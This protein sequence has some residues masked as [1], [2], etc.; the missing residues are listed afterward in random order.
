MVHCRGIDVLP[1][2]AIDGKIRSYFSNLKHFT[3][4]RV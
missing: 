3:P 4:L 2:E 1:I